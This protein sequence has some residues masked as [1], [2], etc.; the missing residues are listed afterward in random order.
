MANPGVDRWSI[1]LPY[2]YPDFSLQVYDF[3]LSDPF[4]HSDGRDLGNSD[5]IRVPDHIFL[6]HL[7]E[8]YNL[9]A[10]VT[11]YSDHYTN[12]IGLPRGYG[13]YAKARPSGIGIDLIVVGHPTGRPYLTMES[14]CVHVH[15]MMLETLDE[16]SCELCTVARE[17]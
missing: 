16:C 15:Y 5:L 3:D 17:L 8:C 2:R 7:T 14:F 11:I 12:F 13:L 4:Y 6:S 10:K 9:K 1:Q